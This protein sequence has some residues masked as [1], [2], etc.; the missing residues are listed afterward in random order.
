MQQFQIDRLRN[1][2]VKKTYFPR[3]RDL[4]VSPKIRIIEIDLI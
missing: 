3:T 4:V 1:E 2:G